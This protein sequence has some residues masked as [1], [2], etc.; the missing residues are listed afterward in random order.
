[1]KRK[2]AV[3]I[4]C[5][6][7]FGACFCVI[8]CSNDNSS[9][10][11]SSSENSSNNESTENQSNQEETPVTITHTDPADWRAFL[12]EYTQAVNDYED[13]VNEYVK[14][15][16]AHQSSPKNGYLEEQYIKIGN[17]ASSWADKVSTYSSKADEIRSNLQDATDEEVAEYSEKSDDLAQRIKILSSAIVSATSEDDSDYYSDSYYTQ[18]EQSTQSSE[19][20]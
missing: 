17:E 7:C 2:L 3:L 4:C 14:A 19:G 6:L 10:N 13:W 15:A 12:D 16:Q 5:I 9:N 11:N 8:G 20:Q 18:D 1:M